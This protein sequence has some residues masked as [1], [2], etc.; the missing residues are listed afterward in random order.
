MNADSVQRMCFLTC[1]NSIRTRS[2]IAIPT[3]ARYADLA[4]YRAKLIVEAQRD[5]LDSMNFS[6]Q[7]SGVETTVITKL[8][9]MIKLKDHI[10]NQ[11]FYC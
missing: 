1:Y 11:L 9:D 6:D 4:A 2:V 3:P 8:N 7:I 10:L 5:M